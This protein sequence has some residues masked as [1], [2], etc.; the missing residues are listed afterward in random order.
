MIPRRLLLAIR[1]PRLPSNM[2]GIRLNS[3]L[4]E[5]NCTEKKTRRRRNQNELMPRSDMRTQAM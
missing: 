2:I 5:K 3:D 1:M 4:L